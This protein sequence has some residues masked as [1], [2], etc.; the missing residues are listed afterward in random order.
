MPES[1]TARLEPDGDRLN[2]GRGAVPILGQILERHLERPAGVRLE[3]P[4]VAPDGPSGAAKHDL[5]FGI[6]K[7]ESQCQL[8]YR[9]RTGVRYSRCEVNHRVANIVFRRAHSRAA[10]L[11]LRWIG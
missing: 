11:D 9:A 2:G 3:R 7:L 1:C 8:A 10:D 5:V 4:R 6:H